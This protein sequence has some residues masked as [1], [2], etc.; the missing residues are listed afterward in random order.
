MLRAL[1]ST[2]CRAQSRLCS[3]CK[4]YSFCQWEDTAVEVVTVYA[5]NCGQVILVSGRCISEFCC[6][7][8]EGALR[9]RLLECLYFT[10]KRYADI[11]VWEVLVCRGGTEMPFGDFPGVPMLWQSPVIP[12]LRGSRECP[13]IGLAAAHCPAASLRWPWDHLSNH[14]HRSRYLK[15][16]GKGRQAQ[17]IHFM[18]SIES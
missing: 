3:P 14:Q 15:G 11:M 2:V 13:N 8:A 17:D 9:L 10:V 5:E 6:A 7:I 12:S 16:T 1:K 4:L 18:K